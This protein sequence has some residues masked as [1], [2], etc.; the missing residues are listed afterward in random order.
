MIEDYRS[1]MKIVDDAGVAVGCAGRILV[2]VGDLTEFEG[3]A[4]VNAA[5]SGLLGGGGVDGA[6]HAAGGPE[7]LKECRALR[8]GALK[9]GLPAGQAVS[10]GAGRLAVR[11]VLHTVGPVWHGGGHGE[12]ETLASCYRESLRIAEL[13][14]LRHVAFPAISTGVY[15]YPKDPA[16]VAAISAVRAHLS[17]HAIPERVTLVFRNDEEASAFLTAVRAAGS[18]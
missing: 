10:T 5:N 14:G 1:T 17:A 12:A 16:A 11:R 7:I 8:A 2:A 4:I 13:E 15:G 18:A 6:I 9:D 3:D